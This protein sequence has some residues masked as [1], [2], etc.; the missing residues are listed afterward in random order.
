MESET[1][2]PNLLCEEDESTLNEHSEEKDEDLQYCSVSD[3][4]NVFVEMPLQRE[5]A[6]RWNQR[7]WLKRARSDA[8]KWIIDTKAIFRYQYRTAYLSLIYIDRFLARRWISEGQLW[9][10]K[11]LSVACLSL[12]AKMEEIRAMPVTR[13]HVEGYNFQGNTI[14]KMELMVLNTLEWKMNSVTPFA[15]LNY[16][17]TKFCD[18]ETRRRELVIKAAEVIFTIIGEINLVEHQSSTIAAASVLAAYNFQLTKTELD[19][20]IDLVPSLEKEHTSS[21]YRLLQEMLTLKT[22]EAAAIPPNSLQIDESTNASRVGTKRRLDF[23]DG[24]QESPS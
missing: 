7:K 14:Q 4:D 24:D 23:D 21:F 5:I 18:D 17:V 9:N 20:K 16:F 10:I 15:Y 13:Y 19:S 12:A 22:P 6:F 1:V 8:I 11:I 2:S 3:A